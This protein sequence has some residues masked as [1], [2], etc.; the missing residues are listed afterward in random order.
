MAD[1]NHHKCCIENCKG[2][3]EKV[4]GWWRYYYKGKNYCEY[5]WNIIQYGLKGQTTFDD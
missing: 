4:C 5:H 3:D 1:I 2:Y